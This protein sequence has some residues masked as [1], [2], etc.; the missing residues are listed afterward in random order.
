MD[1][2]QKL[3]EIKTNIIEMRSTLSRVIDATEAHQNVIGEED[4]DSFYM[5]VEQLLISARLLEHGITEAKTKPAD[6]ISGN[7]VA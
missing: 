1:R 6:S 2:T 5:A 3:L 4:L 7:K